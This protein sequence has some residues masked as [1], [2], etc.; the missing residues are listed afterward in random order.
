ME[1]EQSSN[2]QK[3]FSFKEKLSKLNILV[4]GAGGIGC[5]LLK[6]LVISGFKNISIVDM[7]KIEISNLNRQFLFDRSCIGKYKSEMAILSIE[8]FRKDKSLNLKSYI[9][10]IKDKSQ[11]NNKFFT[12]FDIILNALDNIDARYYINSICMKLNIPLIDSGT[13]GF[14]GSVV[15]HI[16]NLTQ[17]YA[18]SLKYK[19]KQ[20]PICTIRLSPEKIEHCVAW[21][22]AL[23]E[24]IFCNNDNSDRDNKN[25]NNNVNSNNVNSDNINSNNLSNELDDYN[26]KKY[27]IGDYY[28]N[29]V[30]IMRFLF[31][32]EISNLKKSYDISKESDKKRN[33]NEHIKTI[34]IDSIVES[35]FCDIEKDS[36]EIYEKF[37]NDINEIENENIDINTL[38]GIFY[39]SYKKLSLRTDINGFNKDDD[40]IIDFIFASSNLR[41]MNF[42]LKT[43]SKFKI[44]Q[45]AGNIIP[46]ISS[47]NN[48][49]SS[50]QIMECIKYFLNSKSIDNLKI[51]NVSQDQKI[52]SMNS[53][54]EEINKDCPVCSIKDNNKDINLDIE[55]NLSFEKNNIGDLINKIEEYFNKKIDNLILEMENNLIYQREDDMDEFE[56]SGFEENKKKVISSFIKDKNKKI[57]FFD[58]SINED[59]YLIIVNNSDLNHINDN[60]NEFINH[61]RERNENLSLNEEK[62]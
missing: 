36:K 62:Y 41:A 18:C 5:E 1:I 11:F 55:F 49:I 42:S 61:K 17:C 20:I 26:F 33:N 57:V 39:E 23:F 43:S 56:V 8:K 52:S 48:I 12:Q 25:N 27:C 28:K 24:R 59:N 32:E 14:T 21:S 50:L 4:I 29:I 37:E 47:T 34:D 54:D 2:E 44:K 9:G 16:K 46:A 38:I 35:E 19:Q 22:K 45:I 6:F 13:T 3:D 51:I 10:N 53:I 60:K 58:L 31:N 40:T 7:D 30:F 15:W